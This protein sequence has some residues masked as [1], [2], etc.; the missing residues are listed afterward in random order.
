M[1]SGLGRHFNICF[2][3][4]RVNDKHNNVDVNLKT[5]SYIRTVE[6]QNKYPAPLLFPWRGKSKQIEIII[7]ENKYGIYPLAFRTILLQGGGGVKGSK[8][9]TCHVK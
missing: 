5:L 2:F 8:F 4:H 7:E 9:M 3:P 6:A 1:Q